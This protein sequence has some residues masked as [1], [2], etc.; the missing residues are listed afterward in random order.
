MKLAKNQASSEHQIGDAVIGRAQP[1]KVARIIIRA[2]TILMVEVQHLRVFGVSTF[3]ACDSW[4]DCSMD[5]SDALYSRSVQAPASLGAILRGGPKHGWNRKSRTAHNAGDSRFQVFHL[6]RG[7]AGPA[8]K[9]VLRHR[10]SRSLDT[11]PTFGAIHG[12]SF[13]LRDANNQRAPMRAKATLG[14]ESRGC[15]T[16]PLQELLAA[17]LACAGRALAELRRLFVGWTARNTA[18]FP[19]VSSFQEGGMAG[20]AR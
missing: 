5:F 18:K 7:T 15:A 9:V 6:P 12:D 2:I 16:R 13:A 11:N 19:I 17:P 1:L 14:A 8:A 3:D 10:A 4:H 20:C